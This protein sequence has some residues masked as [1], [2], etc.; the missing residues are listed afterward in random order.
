MLA[1]LILSWQ[2]GTNFLKSTMVDVWHCWLEPQFYGD[3]WGSLKDLYLHILYAK[4]KTSSSL[5]SIY[6]QYPRMNRIVELAKT[7]VFRH[8]TL[9]SLGASSAAVTAYTVGPTVF[10]FLMPIAFPTW[11]WRYYP[12]LSFLQ[13]NAAPTKLHCRDGTEQ[14]MSGASKHNA[15]QLKQISVADTSDLLEDCAKYPGPLS[16]PC[17]LCHVSQVS[18]IVH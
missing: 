14:V 7:S 18:V 5:L 4:I 2:A 8:F 13:H 15:L 10:F 11:I 12:I 9:S 1:E 16:D 3:V 6:T 17:F